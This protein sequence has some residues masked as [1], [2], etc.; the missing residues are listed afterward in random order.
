MTAE[1]IQALIEQAKNRV[2]NAENAVRTADYEVAELESCLARAKRRQQNAK[3][4]LAEV[5]SYMALLEI[6]LKGAQS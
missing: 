5:G 1:E 4:S 2:A 6:A 3:S